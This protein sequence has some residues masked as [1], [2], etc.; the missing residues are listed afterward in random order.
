[1]ISVIV[2]VY[3]A[4]PYLQPLIDSI[5]N[6]TWHNL[7]LILVDDG[8]NDGSG[9]V[10]DA[11]ALQDSRVCVIHKENAGQ[12]AAR[13]TG[14]EYA[15]GDVIAF[16]DHDDIL[17][18]NAYEDMMEAMQKNNTLVCACDFLNV[19][20][21]D[22]E[23]IIFDMEKPE[24]SV[25]ECEE[26]LRDLFTPSWRTP[27][28]NKLYHRSVLQDI[29]F[30]TFR[31]GEDNLLSYQVLKACHRT[32]FVHKTLYFQRMHGDNFEFT[33]IRYF[34]DL[35]RAKERILK[36]VKSSF[37]AEHKQFQKRLLYECIRIYNSYVDT[38]DSQYAAQKRE[39]IDIFKR[40]LR[41]LWRSDMPIGH[42]ILFTKLRIK[43][44]DTFK[45][46]IVI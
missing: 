39:T 25:V 3:N 29:R 32:A 2:P 15:S 4:G 26:W 41:G 43:N 30:G 33:G 21:R 44:A 24:I 9:V 12:S 16:A 40:N 6:Q 37:P 13:N 34:T 18:P 23:S 46:R 10:C 22:M 1:M 5:L 17:H 38:G 8:S 11:A 27:I 19:Q 20:Q 35:L 28:W 36:D 45:Q 7:E 14:L 31:L 42:K